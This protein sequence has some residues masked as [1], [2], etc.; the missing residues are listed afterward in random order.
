[1]ASE[2]IIEDGTGVANANSYAAAADARA[3]A[4]L[5]GIT[6]PAAGAGVDP[7]EVF[8]VLAAEYL[9]SRAWVG[10]LATATQGLAWPRVFDFPLLAYPFYPYEIAG[11]W[12][13]Y[14]PFDPSY[15]VLPEKIA[16]AQC[17]LVIEQFNGVVLM[18]TTAGG[19]QFITR[20]K[21]DTIETNY[22]EKLGTLSTPTMPIVTSLLRGLQIVG[23]GFTSLRSV[24]G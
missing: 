8:L 4:A 22:S 10:Y 1:M 24:R 9:D 2:L 5:R 18:P 12:E 17:Q 14:L 13:A 11:Y 19:T 20:E 21:T 7:V 6:L 23:G 15:Y 3:Y 16:A